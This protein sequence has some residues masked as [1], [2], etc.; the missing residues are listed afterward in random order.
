MT[1]VSWVCVTTMAR[2]IALGVVCII[3]STGTA[4]GQSLSLDDDPQVPLRSSPAVP[5][6]G[7]G[8]EDEFGVSLPGPAL[9][10]SPSITLAPA[11]P[12]PGLAGGDGTI[13]STTVN[14]LA[15]GPDGS[16]IDAF[17]TN[18]EPVWGNISIDFSV[19]R[20]TNGIAG[21]GLGVEANNNQQPGDIYKSTATFTDPAVFAGS[22]AGMGA[23][24]FVGSLPTA[25]SAP[26]GSNTLLIDD[27]ALGLTVTG[28][29]G[30]TTPA[31]IQVAAAGPGT[32]DNVDAFDHGSQIAVGAQPWT[33]VYPVHSYFAIAPDEAV[34]V[35]QSAA[36]IYDTGANAGGTIAG[37]PF[38]TAIKM[39]LDSLG[40]N[41]DSIDALVMFDV[42]LIGGPNWS[43]PGGQ[44]G[45]DYALFSLAPGSASL[46][47]AG[48]NLSA[49]DVLFTD[50][51]NRFAVYALS[52]DLGMFAALGGAA[53]IGDNIDAL[54]IPE[55]AT[56]S[57]LAIGGLALIRRRRR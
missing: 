38:A 46:S 37:S 10:P 45:I 28:V 14:G 53:M 55:P 54:E 49:N 43:G 5:P 26:G 34:V 22:L 29:V 8:A 3:L 9:A 47:A 7:L 52:T 12:G 42:S 50:F 23:G 40:T 48:F 18:H 41:T 21:S 11:S 31:G 6:V 15:H 20:L 39:G 57:L 51:T 32:H 13:F 44:G 24:P 19:D 1:H 56:L 16:W 36:H 33:G 30:T 2:G 35:G 27:S 4:W 17:S 25:G